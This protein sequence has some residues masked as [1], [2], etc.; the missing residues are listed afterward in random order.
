M[1]G[2]PIPVAAFVLT[3]GKTGDI[4]KIVTTVSQAV[5]KAERENGLLRVFVLGIGDDVSTHVCEKIARAG[6]G[7]PAYIGVSGPLV[8]S[9]EVSD[10]W[11][12]ES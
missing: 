8:R 7:V 9:V 11:C 6:K 4:S 1:N 5:A 3:D 10:N 2:K 12:S